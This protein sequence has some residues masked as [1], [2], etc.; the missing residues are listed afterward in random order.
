MSKFIY[1]KI[2]VELAN[3][4]MDWTDKEGVDWDI[5]NPE[6]IMLGGDTV[7]LGL[8]DWGVWQGYFE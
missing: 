4:I 3:Q 2:S 6:E 8:V 5:W 1:R 7:E